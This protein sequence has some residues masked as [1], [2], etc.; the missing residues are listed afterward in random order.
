[1]VTGSFINE[2]SNDG[3]KSN[4]ASNIESRDGKVII[5]SDQDSN[6]VASNIIAQKGVETNANGDVNIVAGID[7]AWNSH[8]KKEGKHQVKFETTSHELSVKSGIRYERDKQSTHKTTI[9]SSNISSAG[10]DVNLTSENDILIGASNVVAAQDVSLDAKENIDIISKQQVTENK[11]SNFMVDVG[12]RLGLDHNFGNM[13]DSLEGLG[14][15]KLGGMAEDGIKMVDAI[16]GAGDMDEA[17]SG[18]EEGINDTMRMIEAYQTAKQGPSPSLA[19]SINAEIAGNKSKDRKE[20]SVGSLVLAGDDIKLQ[21][22]NSD[23]KIEGS[24]VEGGRNVVI[25]AGDEVKII[26]AKNKSSSKDS[27]YNLEIDVD[28][29]GTSGV[30]A[31]DI[32]G[33]I[34]S[35]KSTS[36]THNN[37]VVKAGDKLDLGAKGDVEVKGANI[38]AK[39]VEMDVEGN[40]DIASLQN[41]SSSKNNA[42]NFNIGI[43]GGGISAGLGFQKGKSK[44]DWVDN[45]TSII[46]EDKVAIN[47]SKNMDVTGALI[48]NIKDGED[49]GNLAIN[50][51]S[52]TYKDLQDVDKSRNYGLNVSGGAEGKSKAPQLA[53]VGFNYSMHDKRQDSN[54]TIGEGAINI[55]DKSDISGLNRDINKAQVITKDLKVNPIKG[56]VKVL[57]KEDREKSLK[58]AVKEW[59]RGDKV[60]TGSV[61][62]VAREVGAKQV[63]SGVNKLELGIDKGVDSV[64]SVGYGLV[65]YKGVSITGKESGTVSIKENIANFTANRE[66]ISSLQEERPDLVNILNNKS[67]YSTTQVEEAKRELANRVTKYNGIADANVRLVLDNEVRVRREGDKVIME[68]TA[69]FYEKGTNNININMLSDH[70]MS[71]LG[72]VETLGHELSHYKGNS[73]EDYASLD[74][75][76]LAGSLFGNNLS[77]GN[78]YDK[79]LVKAR[80]YISGQ[81]IPPELIENSNIANLVAKEDRENYLT[82]IEK[83]AFIEEYKDAYKKEGFGAIK[84]YKEY[85]DL[86]DA[87]DKDL[88]KLVKS[89]NNGNCIG[90]EKVHFDLREK[91]TEEGRKYYDNGNQSEF[92]VENKD[93][94]HTMRLDEKGR[95]FNIYTESQQGVKKLVHP[96]YG[97]EVVLDATGQHVEDDVNIATYNFYNAGGY[98]IGFDGY[99]AWM[100]NTAENLLEG[101]LKHNKYDVLP[102]YTLGNS[103]N[104]KSTEEQRGD[105]LSNS[106]LNN[107]GV[108]KEKQFK[109]EIQDFM[110]S[111]ERSNK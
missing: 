72:G 111:V 12:L 76:H 9:A 44:R 79:N 24:R 102:Y 53:G 89:C 83:K 52:L 33:G 36:L 15:V 61:K 104:D 14:D 95:P 68:Q 98:N 100:K 67:Q 91:I 70:N 50:T 108:S 5:S 84:V 71:A 18:N 56:E 31:T 92:A 105:R 10:G 75:S 47:V 62:Q 23:I 63:V 74:G 4:V 8:S 42:L 94:F 28:I 17:L 38:L 107:F 35:S 85:K 90:L 78:V 46:G 96:V 43:G 110:Y 27:G 26:A 81:K 22:K 88:D 34:H 106:V 65:G 82:A 73:R 16:I 6:I 86:S 64:A 87:R 93:V 54:A 41:S 58:D 32:S 101:V 19:L 7:S 11:S 37:S 13:A 57:T 55:S 59:L 109:N 2:K 29:I 66:A 80:E 25:D 20:Q 39:E 97:Y 3:K 1:M 45:Q 77:N 40:L 103:R 69:G 21:A 99:P 48:G 51:S 60:I 30:G 49:G